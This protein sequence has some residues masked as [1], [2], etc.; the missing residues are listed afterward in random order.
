MQFIFA[1]DSRQLHPSRRD[2]RPFVAIGGVHVAANVVRPL[3]AALDRLC[4]ERGFPLGEEFKWSP[5]RNTWMHSNLHDD[6]RRDFFSTV[7]TT[8]AAHAVKVTVVVLDAFSRHAYRQ[9]AGPEHDATTLFLERADNAF[10]SASVCGVVVIDR[11]GGGRPA[12]DRFLSDCMAT[13]TTGTDYVDMENVAAVLTATSHQARVLQLAD[14]VTGCVGARVAG[15][16]TFS[17][18]IFEMVKPLFRRDAGRTGGVGLKIHPD[19][20]YL[21]LYHWLVGDDVFLKGWGAYPLP[22]E[23]KLY[24]AD[25][26]EAAPAPVSPL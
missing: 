21:N 7:M 16:H 10:R 15:E 17:P 9:S 1:D 6:D 5:R 25:A 11:P 23:G 12:E 3:S 14:V 22:R 2:M 4:V 20:R 13:I 8:A 24:F 26:G 18:P 19:L